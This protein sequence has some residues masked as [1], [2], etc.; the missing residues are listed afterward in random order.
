[1]SSTRIVICDDHPLVR[2]GVANT[3]AS[4]PDCEVV[5]EANDVDAA[6]AKLQLYR[7]DVLISDLSLPGR[8]GFELLEWTAGNMPAV[9]MIVV[10]MYSDIA[11]VR[12]AEAIGAVAYIA[13]EDAEAELLLA[14]R[15]P[16]GRFHTSQSVGRSAPPRADLP[17]SDEAPLDLGQVSAA[18]MRVL[19]L[20]SQSLTSREI[21]GK[22]NISPRTVETHRM[23][24]AEKLEAKG[25]NKLLELAIRHRH[26]LGRR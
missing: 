21:A 7:P 11:F 23:R 1:M 19:V 12:K 26:S 15:T 4:S 22:L 3:L 24:L 17:P 18:E 9:R 10:S 5:A 2:K 20:L 25:P 14:L 16:P 8:S 13:K 6:I